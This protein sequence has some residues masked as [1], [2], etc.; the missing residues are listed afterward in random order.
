MDNLPSKDSDGL[1]PAYYVLRLLGPAE[2]SL[3]SLRMK[4]D[5]YLE[6]RI[7]AWESHFA[8]MNHS[9][10]SVTAPDVVE[11]VIRR[12]KRKRLLRSI[13]KVSLII[14]LAATVI[15]KTAIAAWLLD[16]FG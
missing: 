16:A 3:T 6:T 13:A 8:A 5:A 2:H 12:V 9:F 14:A 11:D 15:G 7:L 1:L 4:T 10:V